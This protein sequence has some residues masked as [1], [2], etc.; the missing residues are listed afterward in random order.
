MG[1]L[2]DAVGTGMAV[3]TRAAFRTTAIAPPLRLRPRSLIVVTH[4]RE[5]DVPVAASLIYFR[6]RLWR[7]RFPRMSFAARDDMFLAGF[8]A[9]FPAKLPTPARALLFPIGIARWLPRVQVHPLR[10]ATVAR[11]GEVV[12]VRR[13]EPVT[14]VFEP[15]EAAAFAAR[16]AAC[17]LSQPIRAGDLLRGE[18]ADLLWRPV[19]PSDP[20]SAGLDAFWSRRAAQ[21]ARDFRNLVELVRAGGVLV[22]FPEG[23]PSPDGAIGPIQRGVA[24]LVRR[25][26]PRELLPVAL[27]YDP[28]TRGRTRLVVAIGPPAATPV[29]RIDDETLALLRR[30]MPLTVGQVVSASLAAKRDARG[31]AAE[32]VEEARV[33]GRPVEPD[34]VDPRRGERRLAEALAV[35]ER[36]RD[37]VSLLAREYGS[38]REGSG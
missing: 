28:L 38:A 35:A 15:P 34:L 13:E 7:H 1:I 5:T 24:A 22:L 4:R 21:S 32:A 16:A 37:A 30:T 25:A 10:S 29:D 12:R 8:F 27:A 36:K 17:G 2:Y 26:E 18:F 33:A 31:L 19:S 14:E 20:V 23:R 6:S 11:L 9:G 3:Y